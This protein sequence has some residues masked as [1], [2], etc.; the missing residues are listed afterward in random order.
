MHNTFR[1]YFNYY[2]EVAFQTGNCSKNMVCL[3]RLEA[4]DYIV[5]DSVLTIADI[6]DAKGVALNIPP[7]KTNDQLTDKEITTRRIAAHQIHV[8]CA[9]GRIKQFKIL[10]DIPNV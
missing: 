8:E 1:S 5:D 10:N 3:E 7:M 2:S 4:G 9:K 6:L